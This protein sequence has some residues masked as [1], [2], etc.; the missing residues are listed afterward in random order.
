V[1]RLLAGECTEDDARAQTIVATRRFARRQESWFRR[2]PRIVWLAADGDVDGLLERALAVCAGEPAAG[3]TGHR[4]AERV[5]GR[6]APDRI[7]QRRGSPRGDPE[8]HR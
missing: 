7:R 3:Q 2:D 8:Q 1:L 4:E 5:P 6:A